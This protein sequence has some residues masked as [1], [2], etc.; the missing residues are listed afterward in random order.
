MRFLSLTPLWLAVSFTG[1]F[2]LPQMDQHPSRIP[3]HADYERG[4]DHVLFTIGGS[5]NHPKDYD[6]IPQRSYVVDPSGL[7]HPI[8]IKPHDFDISERF[9]FI[10]DEIFV[11]RSETVPKPIQL[12]DGTWKFVLAY[13]RSGVIRDDTFS[14][15]IWT[16]YYNP[17]VHGPP[18]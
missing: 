16:F 7:H 8:R 14:V 6:I 15:R 11:L 4:D 9:P 10:R 2:P 5:E 13:R 3:F 1:C 12:H 18:N 17:I